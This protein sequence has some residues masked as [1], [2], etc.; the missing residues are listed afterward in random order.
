MA[1]LA[2]LR[3]NAARLTVTYAGEPL[4]TVVYRPTALQGD[5]FDRLQSGDWDGVYAALA[6]V[7]ASWDLT[8]GGAPVP[9]DPTG[10][11]RAG[12]AVCGTLINAMLRDMANPTWVTSPAPATPTPSGNGSSP[13]ASSAPAPTTSISS[14]PPNG[15]TSPPGISPVS[16]PPLVTPAGSPGS[17]A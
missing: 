8:D 3:A 6:E 17:T 11:K 12:F 9:V 4:A 10:F 5:M 1:D 2:S 14:E 16:P 7:V 15:H 13:A